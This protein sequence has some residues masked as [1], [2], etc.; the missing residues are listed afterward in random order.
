MAAIV[1]PEGEIDLE[2]FLKK[3]KKSVPPYAQPLFLRLLDHISVT[4]EFPSALLTSNTYKDIWRTNKKQNINKCTVEK[5]YYC[6]SFS[7]LPLSTGNKKW[8][9]T[10][11]LGTIFYHW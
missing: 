8:D 2:D 10:I 4:G 6:F 11:Y 9:D 1:D 3:I 5:F 7:N